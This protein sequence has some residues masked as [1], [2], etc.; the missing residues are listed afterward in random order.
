MS[1]LSFIYVQA[2]VPDVLSILSFRDV[3]VIGV[4]LVVLWYFWD[5]VKKLETKIEEYIKNKD[6]DK[7]KYYDL[8]IKTNEVIHENNRI[9]QALQKILDKKLE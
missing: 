8:V 2:T 5:R 6:E 3:G 7:L 4:L 1:L 9:M